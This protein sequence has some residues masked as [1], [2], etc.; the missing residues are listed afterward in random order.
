MNI[1]NTLNFCRRGSP[2]PLLILLVLATGCDNSTGPVVAN[3]SGTKIRIH[4]IEGHSYLTFLRGGIIHAESCT[5][6]AHVPVPP[7]MF[8]LTPAIIPTPWQ[9]SVSTDP[10]KTNIIVAEVRTNKPRTI[11]DMLD[12]LII[13]RALSRTNQGIK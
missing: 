1:K 10:V 12:D 5:N 9:G 7:A 2:L 3:H 8:Q 13:L 6:A 4:T 11:D